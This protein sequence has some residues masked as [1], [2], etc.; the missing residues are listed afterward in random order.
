MKKG[1]VGM[2]KCFSKKNGNKGIVFNY[3]Q[4][5]S[6]VKLSVSA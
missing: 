2:V 3:P 5:E 1:D 6:Y 4:S